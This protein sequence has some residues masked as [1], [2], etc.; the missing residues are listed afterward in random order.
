MLP[1]SIPQS[2]LLKLQLSPLYCSQSPSNAEADYLCKLVEGTFGTSL[3]TMIELT[4]GIGVQSISF[5]AR[6]VATN[7]VMVSS[8]PSKLEGNMGQLLSHFSAEG[9][10]PHY[11]LSKEKE[12]F[13]NLSEIRT[14]LGKAKSACLY[15]DLYFEMTPAEIRSRT[16]E[17]LVDGKSLQSCLQRFV[18]SIRWSSSCSTLL[19]RCPDC[20][21]DS[22]KRALAMFEI[23]EHV[24][25]QDRFGSSCC[26]P[27]TTSFLVIHPQYPLCQTLS[28]Q[29]KHHYQLSTVWSP[30]PSCPIRCQVEEVFSTVLSDRKAVLSTLYEA[31]QSTPPK[32]D[33]SIWEAAHAA[34]IHSF[35]FP[36]SRMSVSQAQTVDRSIVRVYA[37]KMKYIDKVVPTGFRPRQIVC[38]GGVDAH[39]GHDLARMYNLEKPSQV[40]VLAEGDRREKEHRS[41]YTFCQT[42]KRGEGQAWP[43]Y[44]NTVLQWVQETL[45]DVEEVDMIVTCCPHAVPLFGSILSELIKKISNDGYLVIN[46]H[47][48]TSAA[49]QVSMDIIHG[50]HRYVTTCNPMYDTLRRED[51][52]LAEGIDEDDQCRYRSTKEWEE[53]LLLFG[54]KRVVNSKNKELWNPMG[55]LKTVW[56]CFSYLGFKNCIVCFDVPEGERS[57][58]WN[59]QSDASVLGALE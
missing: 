8:Q 17:V 51:L 16:K 37:N 44:R 18:D 46:D 14:I 43:D 29:S 11:L 30:E 39:L 54:L 6:R 5:V 15:L 47:S 13:Q 36:L 24:F 32:D 9:V 25:T 34:Y 59:R 19:L 35:M 23:R 45:K 38:V 10:H 1:P 31:I 55:N 4:A 22:V 57:R 49:E 20:I 58:K 21:T 12:V 28:T 52:V 2:T 40:L 3:D 41:D 56:G 53:R 26:P 42:P 48:V 50:F 7:L 27:H 33:R